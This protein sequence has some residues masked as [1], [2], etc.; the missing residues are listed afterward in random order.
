MA[1]NRCQQTVPEILKREADREFDYYLAACTG[2]GVCSLACHV[3]QSHRES[4]FLPAYRIELLRRV[5]RQVWAPVGWLSAAPRRAGEQAAELIEKLFTAA[6]T[7]TG[8]RR[9]MVYCP[10]GVDLS[11][12]VSVGKAALA[13]LGRVPE[14]LELLTETAVEKGNSVHLY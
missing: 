13:A 1:H 14:E 12:V 6:Y 2:C 5:Y 11:W 9:C 8:C 3:S 4:E 7:C 10:F